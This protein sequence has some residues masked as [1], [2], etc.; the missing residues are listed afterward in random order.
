MIS[1]GEASE[2]IL[3]KIKPLGAESVDLAQAGG[4][5]L[6]E[7]VVAATTS[8]PWDNASMD[9]YAVRSTDSFARELRPEDVA[10]RRLNCGR[11]IERS[12]AWR[13][14]GDAHNDG[15]SGAGRR[16]HRH[17]HRRHRPGR[18]AGCNR[19][20]ARS[21]PEYP[22]RRRGFS[23]GRYSLRAVNRAARGARR[24]SR[25]RGR[26]VG[27]G[28][29]LA[30]EWRSSAQ[31]MSWWSSRVLGMP[32]TTRQRDPARV[33]SSRPTDGHSAS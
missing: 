31:A 16:R 2:R 27:V 8:P 19:R 25:F 9:G 13:R 11:G 5:V 20:P 26:T 22:A 24:R 28:F 4:R 21:A 6:A 30:Q 12:S 33:G 7:S 29:P 14:R 17:P 1:V 18:G 3:K 10:S 15:S 23:R 32:Q